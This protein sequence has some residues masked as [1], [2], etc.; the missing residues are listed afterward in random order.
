MGK[1]KKPSKYSDINFINSLLPDNV[2]VKQPLQS[3]KKSVV[4]TP[5]D[6]TEH[7]HA[8]EDKL[9]RVYDCG[10]YRMVFTKDIPVHI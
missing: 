2:V 9:Y 5:K 1:W 8:L 6:K 3:R 10:K 7:E 4:G